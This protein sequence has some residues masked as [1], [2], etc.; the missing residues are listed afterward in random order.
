VSKFWGYLGGT[1]TRP[2]LT[3]RNLLNDPNR[4]LQGFGAVLLIG[5]LYTLTVIGLAVVGAEITTPAWVSIPASEYY[6]REIFFAIPVYFMVWILAAG[7]VQIV[8]KAFGG[9][10]SFEGT[11][12][13]LGLA[14]TLPSF[15][16]W[17]PE[18]IGTVLMLFGLMSQKEW[19]DIVARPGFWQVFAA[20]YQFVAVAWFLLLFP[21]AVA[22]AQKIRW[23]PSAIVGILT[24]AIAGFVIFIFIR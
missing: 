23:W 8:S 21:I 17:I 11:F 5:V 16:T 13:V 15:V 20:A 1:I 10:G 3:F 7:I 22:V 2:Q 9:Q 19:L 12:A 24:V 18:T 4:L 6:F 14:L